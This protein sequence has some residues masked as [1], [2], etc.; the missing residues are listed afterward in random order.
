MNIRSTTCPDVGA[1]RAWL[2]REEHAP[3]LAQ[4]LDSCAA[5]R[6]HVGNLRHNAAVASDALRTVSATRLPTAAEIAIARERLAWRER[7]R[8]P[9]P[10]AARSAPIPQEITPVLLSRI[11]TPWRVAA[12]GIAAALLVSLVVAFT[13]EGRTAAAGFLAQFRSQQVAA[14]EVS[15]QSQAEIM[16]TLN[17]LGN[18]GTIKSGSTTVSTARPGVLRSDAPKQVSLA[19]AAQQVG[20]AIQTPDPATL[21][22]GMDRTPRVE[23]MPAQQ[24]SFTFDKTKAAEY[25]RS[26]GR[27]NVT[28]PDKFDGA[29]LVVSMPAAVLLQYGGQGNRDALIIG[30]AGELVVDVQGKVSLDEMR[31]FLLSLPGLPKETTD[32]LRV[33]RNWNQTLPVP[34]PTDKINWKTETFKGSQGLLLNDNSGVG[35]AAI[36]QTGGHLYGLAGSMKASDLKRVAESLR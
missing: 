15:P 6:R 14:I 32:Q 3:D 11:S 30:Q 29:T 19:E 36:F 20:F 13:P 4:H 16:R 12:S 10:V 21:P 25:F 27:V 31:D 2:D 34:I 9:A 5:C 24:Y 28:V 17:T 18:L 23:V 8:E 26:N 7:Q 1:W 22:A 35:S 33:L